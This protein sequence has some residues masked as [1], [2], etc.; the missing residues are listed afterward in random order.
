MFKLTYNLHLF[1]INANPERLQ[2]GS[3]GIEK[4]NVCIISIS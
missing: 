1:T 4:G 3:E 2:Q